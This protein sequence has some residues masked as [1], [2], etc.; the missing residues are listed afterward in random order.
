MPAGRYTA[1]SAGGGHVCAL[2]T[3]GTIT[4]WGDNTNGAASAPDGQYSAV[5]AGL[6]HSCGLRTD[7]T[8]TCWGWNEYGQATAPDS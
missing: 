8:I 4:C 2:R 3:D 5:D 7:G 6:A 1:V